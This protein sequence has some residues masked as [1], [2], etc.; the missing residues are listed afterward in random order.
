MAEDEWDRV[1]S[2]HLVN[3]KYLLNLFLFPLSLRS[4]WIQDLVS[5]MA[6]FPFWMAPRELTHFPRAP[7]WSLSP[8]GG[9]WSQDAEGAG[10]EGSRWVLWI[11]RS[12]LR[13]LCQ[14]T[15]VANRGKALAAR[16][17]TGA[18]PWASGCIRLL[19]TSNLGPEKR[20]SARKIALRS[21]R[22][23]QMLTR[24]ALWSILNPDNLFWADFQGI[25]G[26][27]SHHPAY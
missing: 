2:W 25:S 16:P 18:P 7:G 3:G 17:R 24:G 23:K 27:A 5:G 20:S 1:C 13:A 21:W 9:P 4:N 11:S 26:P 15:L 8:Q 12:L 22:Q 14:T 6:S 10:P 19:P